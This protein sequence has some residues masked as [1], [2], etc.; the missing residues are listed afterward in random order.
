M[1]YEHHQTTTHKTNA[2]LVFISHVKV[3]SQQ[4]YSNFKGA[5]RFSRT[6]IMIFCSMKKEIS[7]IHADRVNFLIS[8]CDIYREKKMQRKEINRQRTPLS[9]HDLLYLI[10]L[11]FDYW[12]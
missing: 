5:A 6:N 12:F 9:A 8:C 3:L 2:Y 4:S 7:E 11:Y 10:R 1:S